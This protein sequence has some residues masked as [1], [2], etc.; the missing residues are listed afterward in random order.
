M[1]S[2]VE[3]YGGLGSR[4]EHRPKGGTGVSSWDY[5]RRGPHSGFEV[6]ERGRRMWFP[7]RSGPVTVEPEGVGR[8]L[9]GRQVLHGSGHRCVGPSGPVGG[10]RDDG[11]V[12]S[13]GGSSSTGGPELVSETGS[14]GRGGEGGR[15]VL[16]W[17]DVG[18]SGR[19]GGRCPAGVVDGRCQA[20]L[21]RG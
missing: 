6:L 21:L 1:M 9:R 10:G 8:P 12:H 16:G 3:R 5:G 7:Q 17:T 20:S 18:T 14:S 15:W 2:V 4:T 19:T 11:V 13:R